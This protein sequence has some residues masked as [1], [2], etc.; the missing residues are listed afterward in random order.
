MKANSTTRK[1]RHFVHR[2]RERIKA[3]KLLDRLQ[4]HALGKIEMKSSQIRAAKIL[5][6]R[7]LPSLRPDVITEESD[8]NFSGPV[9]IVH[10]GETDIK[11]YRNGAH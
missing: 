1:G 7:V 3:A 10:V 5:L 8:S 2:S 9:L 4:A 6:D 11:K